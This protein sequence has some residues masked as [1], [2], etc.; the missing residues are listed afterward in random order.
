MRDPYWHDKTHALYTG[1]ARQ[2]LAE[3]SAESADCIITSPP[4]WTPPPRDE[5]T[6]SPSRYG[7]E[8]TPALY[9]AALRRLFAQAHRV[10]NDRGTAW[11]ITGD[12]YAD[13]TGSDGLQEGRHRRRIRDHTMRGVPATSLIGLPWQL[14][15]ALQDDG[16]IVRNAIVWQQFSLGRS[17]ATDRFPLSYELIFLLVKSDR[18][19]FDRGTVCRPPDRLTGEPGLGDNPSSEHG[20]ERS[21]PDSGWQHNRRHADRD[22]SSRD[23]RVSGHCRDRDRAA[24]QP[25]KRQEPE[26]LPFEP[27][28]DVWSLPPRPERHTLPIEV[29]LTCIAAGCRPGGT[30]LD[31]FAADATTGIAARHLGRP[32]IGVEQDLELCRV[33]ERRLRAKSGHGDSD[34]R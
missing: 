11:L 19:Y 5:P 22:G 14:A 8:P 33:A 6:A 2:V 21:A 3:M 4:L 7:R 13:Q 18:Y 15:F 12:R 32:F 17:A 30:V 16:W 1:D 26:V 29:P 28:G 27:V 9:L 23:G 25:L 34:M 31:M 10:L 20:R 24:R